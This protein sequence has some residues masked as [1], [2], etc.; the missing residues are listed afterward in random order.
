MISG[1]LAKRYARALLQLAS[2]PAQRDRFDKDIHALAAACKTQDDTETPLFAILDTT[3]Y[4]LSERKKVVQAVGR[5]LGSDPMVIKFAEHVVEQGRASGFEQMA[6]HYRD[7]A[8]RKA[9][10][11]RAVV[12]SATRLD[13]GAIAKIKAA[14]EQ[15]TGKT[16]V[17]DT[18]VDPELIGGVVTQVGSHR[19]DRSVKTQLFNLR[20]SLRS[21]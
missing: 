5:K 6:H 15:S 19:I 21:K 12:T 13:A 10:R 3:R 18:D 14:L 17:L 16:V 11:V 4:P 20:E 7:L 2:T 8:D 1:T 9:G